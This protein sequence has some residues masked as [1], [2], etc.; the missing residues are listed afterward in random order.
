MTKKGNGHWLG[1]C[2][3]L[4][5]FIFGATHYPFTVLPDTCCDPLEKCCCADYG[6]NGQPLKEYTCACA[7]GYL[8][9]QECKY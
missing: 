1:L 4:I 7:G 6:P 9:W 8:Q 5:F 2:L 3:L